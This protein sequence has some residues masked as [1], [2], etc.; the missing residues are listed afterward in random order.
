VTTIP[1]Q[2]LDKKEG[3]SEPD[4][5]NVNADFFLSLP[6]LADFLTGFRPAGI[7]NMKGHEMCYSYIK[8]AYINEKQSKYLPLEIKK[9]LKSP[10]GK[11]VDNGGLIQHSK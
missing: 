5:G 9:T 2:I 8:V 4:T 3:H 11:A 6:S 1:E 7:P 10:P